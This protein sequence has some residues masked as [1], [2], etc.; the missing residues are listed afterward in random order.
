[1]T[2]THGTCGRVARRGGKYCSPHHVLMKAKGD[3]GSTCAAPIQAHI[4]SLLALGWDCVLIA[5][6]SGASVRTVQSLRHRATCLNRTANAILAV[7]LVPGTSYRRTANPVLVQRRIQSLQANGWTYKDIAA[8]DDRLTFSVIVACM[9][10]DR[11]PSHATAL[12]VKEVFEKIG[13]T[14]G[15]SLVIANRARAK[16]FFPPAAWD[17]IDDLVEV[18]DLGGTRKDMAKAHLDDL[19]FFASCGWSREKLAARFGV[20]EGYIRD[21]LR[22]AA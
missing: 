15:P 9:S 18:P 14:P 7:A 2:C 17:D 12:L 8:T 4:D 5:K 13:D 6:A 3:V 21:R 1:M 19:V 16:G 11:N 10:E 20:S 22:T